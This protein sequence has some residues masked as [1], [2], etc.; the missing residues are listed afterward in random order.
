MRKLKLFKTLLVAAG[1]TMGASAWAD[2]VYDFR[3]FIGGCTNNHTLVKGSEVKV[4]ESTMYLVDNFTTANY[5]TQRYSAR[6]F[7]TNGR[8]AVGSETWQLRRKTDAGYMIRPSSA[9]GTFSILNL[10]EGDKIVF[11][12]TISAIVR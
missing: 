5:N 12:I 9:A 3:N 2:E 10:N 7:N 1:L 4:G 8:F 11:D 6:D